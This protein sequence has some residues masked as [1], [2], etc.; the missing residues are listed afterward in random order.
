MHLNSP[1]L[2]QFLQSS[3]V[4][5]LNQH[6]LKPKHKNSKGQ[7]EFIELWSL[8]NKFKRL[9]AANSSNSRCFYTQ[10]QHLF[11]D[12]LQLCHRCFTDYLESGSQN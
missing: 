8:S 2:C 6:V 5:L 12:G 1:Q 7:L 9:L 10:I 11:V 3:A 4:S